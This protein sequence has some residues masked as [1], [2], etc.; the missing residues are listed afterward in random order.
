MEDNQP[1]QDHETV[2]QDAQYEV[3]LDETMS[4][5][6]AQQLK[7]ELQQAL[8]HTNGVVVKVSKLERIDA[9]VMQL[10]LAF[11]Q[12][13]KEAEV[14]VSWDGDSDVFNRAVKLLGMDGQFKL[15]EG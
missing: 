12:S 1:N 13:A 9:A 11:V 10:L 2:E 6:E 7:S 5:S 14:D 8:T 15:A 3:V 4:I